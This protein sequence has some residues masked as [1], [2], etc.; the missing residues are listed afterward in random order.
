MEMHFSKPRI[1]K[2]NYLSVVTK[3]LPV[4]LLTMISTHVLRA[5]APTSLTYPTPNVFIANVSSVYLSPSV[6]GNV[7]SYGITPALPAGLSL[8]T[9]TGVISGVPTAASASTVY[10]ITATGGNPSGSTATTVNIQVTNNYFNNSYSNVNFGGTGVTI[11]AKVGSGTAVGDIVVYQNVATL[12]GQPIDAVIK[13]TSLSNGTFTTYDNTVASGSGYSNNEERFFSPQFNFSGAGSAGFD[14]QFILGGTYVSAS[15]IG[16]PIVLQ[17]VQINT[18]DID[19][20][21]S[22]NSNQYN[23]FGGFSSS[24]LGNP[25]RIL[26][27]YNTITN[28]TRFASNS[29]SNSTVVTADSTR[30]RVTYGNMS[31]FSIVMG[32]GASGACYFFLD[33][34]AGPTFSTA[35]STPAPTI[36]LNTSLTGVNNSGTNAATSTLPFTASGQTSI[37]TTPTTLNELDVRF[38]TSSILNGAS[39]QLLISGATSGGTIPLNFANGA[40]VTNIVLGGIT[41]KVTA[42]ASND[43]SMLAFTNNTGGN[44]TPAQFEALLDAFSYNNVSSTPTSG[45]RNFTVNVSNTAFRSPDA[46][47]TAA[48]NYVTVAGKVYR[49]ING[50]TDNLVNASG[51]QFAANLVYL[52]RVNPAN[53]QVI[54]SRAVAADGSYSFG[55]VAT[56]TYF[57]YVSN[58]APAAGSQFTAATYPT[59]GYVSVGEN[60]GSGTGS[61]L[62]TDGKLIVT[63]GSSGGGNANFGIEIP[64]VTANTT[65]GNQSNPGGYNYFTIPAGNFNATDA[66]GSIASI[67]ITAFPTGANYL[68]VGNTIYANPSGGVCPPLTTC[69]AWP[70]TLS[71]PYSGGNATQAISVDPSSD[72]ASSVAISFTATDD[73]GQ[74]SNG[75][76]PSTL[77]IPF[78]VTNYGSIAGTI[79]TD[80]NGNGAKDGAEASTAVANTGQTLYLVLVQNTNTYAGVP[81]VFS[82]TPVSASTGYSLT[83][84]PA[85]SN[86]EVRLLSLA[87]APT[88]GSAAGTL[89]PALA[90]GWTAVSTANGATIVTGLNTVN[91]VIALNG[92]SGTLGSVNIGLERLATADT[93]NYTG[94]NANTDGVT[95]RVAIAN[96]NNSA[97]IYVRSLNMSGTASTGSTPGTLSG[98]DPD[99]GTGGASVNIGSG[100]TGVSLVIDPARYTNTGSTAPAPTMLSY[101]E[102]QLQTGGCKG[103]DAGKPTCSYYNSTTGFWEIPNYDGTLLKVLGTGGTQQ[104]GFFYAWKDGAGATGSFSNYNVSFVQS[105]PLKLVSFGAKENG[106]NTVDLQW[107]TANETN[108]DRFEVERSLDGVNFSRVGTVKAAGSAAHSY[109][110]TDSAPVKGYN[111]YRL[112]IFDQDGTVVYSSTQLV[113]IGALTGKLSVM[114]NP[115]NKSADLTIRW[116]AGNSARAMLTVFESTG[117]QVFKGRLDG[118]GNATIPV[119]NW[120]AGMYYIV[121]EN[122]G[123]KEFAR[124]LVK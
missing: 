83:G 120:P 36:D 69:T 121:T 40:N 94:V 29:S 55:T 74:V 45:N 39:E 110:F 60:F 22:A 37:S 46:I 70:G 98:V 23:E 76:T 118:S 82:S 85:G 109:S 26:T 7:A 95:T 47:F 122:G 104:M 5:Q 34:G 91:P 50:L 115:V 112:S 97:V 28:L 43:T 27:S 124:V 42:T 100:S 102:V 119:H 14:F 6:A 49:D 68:R 19:G 3:A 35:V 18:Y 123:Q 89:T 25:T 56:G 73:A 12:S 88:P 93:K 86:Y 24:D 117:K 38:A 92:F 63:V 17:N 52:V 71:I 105:L 54:D 75:G 87:S 106:N 15:N 67:T 30:A 113:K 32:A 61:D 33:F 1:M 66:D 84:V 116:N 78:V 103:A 21:G 11:S 20:N 44:L 62:L 4:F 31:K 64:P 57:L 81:T 51:A 108:S 48:L 65:M 114:P 96:T 99:G 9:N 13:T 79:F 101:N 77:T 90:T 80:Y 16:T 2:K 59:G 58:S 8:N 72:A 107:N 10:T 111:Y 53:N 41:Y